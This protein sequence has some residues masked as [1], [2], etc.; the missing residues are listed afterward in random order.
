MSDCPVHH[1]RA[2]HQSALHT[3]TAPETRNGGYGIAHVVRCAWAR[4]EVGQEALVMRMRI[5][6]RLRRHQYFSCMHCTLED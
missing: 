6:I 4:V 2:I 1:L 5:V 3:R